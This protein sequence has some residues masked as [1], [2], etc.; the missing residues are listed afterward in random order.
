MTR[1]YKIVLPETA[2][3]NKIRSIKCFQPVLCCGIIVLNGAN[4]RSE[5]CPILPTWQ[6]I[7]ICCMNS[8]LGTS[9]G[10]FAPLINVARKILY[11]LRSSVGGRQL[12]YITPNKG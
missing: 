1:P 4:C 11:V 2:C 7:Y 8:L 9:K 5:V 12:K 3:S 6:Y 10:N